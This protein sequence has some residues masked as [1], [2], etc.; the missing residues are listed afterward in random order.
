LSQLL[1]TLKPAQR[2]AIQ[3]VKIKGFTVKEASL[4][5]GQSVSFVKVNIHRGLAKA[6]QEARRAT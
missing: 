4:K 3:L 1:T 5:T 2:E 6:A